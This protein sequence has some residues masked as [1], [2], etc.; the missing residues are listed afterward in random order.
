MLFQ[1]RDISRKKLQIVTIQIFG[2]FICFGF[3]EG[4]GT[5]FEDSTPSKE[6]GQKRQKSEVGQK[7]QSKDI[8][9]IL[10]EVSRIDL[11][12]SFHLIGR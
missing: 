11:G 9:C 6:S 8:L 3:I 10:K 5:E 1:F 2:L 4:I 12:M 7:C